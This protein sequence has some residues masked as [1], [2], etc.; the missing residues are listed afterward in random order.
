MYR[1]DAFFLGASLDST[2]SV[3]FESVSD[4]NGIS[5][6]AVVLAVDCCPCCC[7]RCW[8]CN[9]AFGSKGVN[10]NQYS[11]NKHVAYDTLVPKRNVGQR[12][13]SGDTIL[14][15]IISVMN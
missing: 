6:M 14:F 4:T 7:C 15:G 11:S 10:D 3:A 8:S 1:Y 2:V 9:I 13:G 5:A 12:Y